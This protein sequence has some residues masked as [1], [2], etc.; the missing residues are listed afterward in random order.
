VKGIQPERYNYKTINGKY[1]PFFEYRVLWLSVKL[2]L[3]CREKLITM[4]GLDQVF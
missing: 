2:D 1:F 4:C 3:P